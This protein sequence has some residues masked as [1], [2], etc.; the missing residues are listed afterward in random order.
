[1]LGEHRRYSQRLATNMPLVHTGSAAPLRAPSPDLG[2]VGRD[3]WQGWCTTLGAATFSLLPTGGTE[4]SLASCAWR[5]GGTTAP[6][7]KAEEL[8]RQWIKSSSESV[9]KP[10]FLALCQADEEQTNRHEIDTC[11]LVPIAVRDLYSVDAAGLTRYP[12]VLG[13]HS[14]LLCADRY[15]RLTTRRTSHKEH[16]EAETDRTN[17]EDESYKGC[18]D[19]RTYKD[20]LE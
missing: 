3:A 10:S 18:V 9:E 19:C 17:H 6:Q 15:W 13:L 20:G 14:D 16:E 2:R 12:C 5:L 4:S 11:S 1:M 8:R 7:E